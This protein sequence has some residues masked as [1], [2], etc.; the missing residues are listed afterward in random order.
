[1]SLN[2][3]ITIKLANPQDLFTCS[4]PRNSFSISGT[5]EK[6]VLYTIGVRKAIANGIL[7]QV[8]QND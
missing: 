4:D 7:I 2:Q 1:M 3:K 6:E 8:I 5:E